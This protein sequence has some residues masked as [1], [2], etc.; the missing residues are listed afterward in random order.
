M[1]F[2]RL[3]IKRYEAESSTLQHSNV[4]IQA[5]YAASLLYIPAIIITKLSVILS[6]RDILTF[7]IHEKFTRIVGGGILIWGVSSELAA[8]FQCR[9]P[10]IWRSNG[11][12]CFDTVS[13]PC[14]LL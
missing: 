4:Y 10:D 11:N 7:G 9:R 2:S 13:P 12:T 6:I 5:L 1:T 8:A 3:R 14:F